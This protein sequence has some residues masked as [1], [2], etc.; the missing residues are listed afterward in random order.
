M[1]KTV[2]GPGTPAVC[3]RSNRAAGFTLVELSIAL[4]IIGLLVG[5]V[6][7]GNDMI[8]AATIRAQIRQL[9]QYNTA[10][11]VFRQR[12]NY[13][14]GDIPAPAATAIG[15]TARAG[16]VGQ[17]DGNGMIKG[18]EAGGLMPA[19]E[20]ALFWTDLST[21][22]LIDGKFYGV[23]CTWNA[24]SGSCSGTTNGGGGTYTL[25]QITPAAKL[26]RGNYLY[27]AGN[28]DGNNYLYV[29]GTGT[30]GDYINTGGTIT[31]GPPAYGITPTE[32]LTIDTKMDDGFPVS[33]KVTDTIW[34]DH[35]VVSPGLVGAAGAGNC[36]N[37]SNGPTV[38]NTQGALNKPVCTL[39]IRAGG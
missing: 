7:V 18:G 6:L 23:D 37:N 12:Y 2:H 3:N 32:A 30:V 14:P 25:G 33:G 5:S 27:V 29:V 8:Q 28:T 39:T 20:A 38:Y 10:V 16:T 17:G 19:G 22:S 35:N 13:L 1:D 11:N 24:T 21:V 4:V 31:G 15:F 36:G 9:D 26:G 34:T